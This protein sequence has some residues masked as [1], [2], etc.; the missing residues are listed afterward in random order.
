MPRRRRRFS[1]LGL[2]YF[3]VTLGLLL[4][5]SVWLDR[6]GETARAVVTRKYE[7]ISVHAVPLGGWDR[8][9][10]VGVQFPT[11]E[12]TLGMATLT[13]P[14]A[15]YDALRPGDS[16]AVHYPPFFPYLARAADRTTLQALGDAGRQ[17]A[18]DPILVPLILWLVAG[19]GSLWLASR[20][21]TPII[22]VVGAGWIVAAFLYLFPAA[23]P[24][25]GGPA[26]ATAR[27]QGVTLIAKA[28]ARRVARR[29]RFSEA[30]GDVRRLSVPYQVA[31]LSFAMPGGDSVLAVDAVDSGSVAGLAFGATVP[32]RYD[33]REPRAARIAG[34]T[35]T[36]LERNRYHF[37]VPVIG[38]AILGMLGAWGAR[39][40]RTRSWREPGAATPAVAPR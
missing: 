18:A 24:P 25:A 33:P 30:F 9:Y 19:I 36:F 28:P 26:A 12:G 34:G 29:R 40:R 22:A 35:R 14:R 17:M 23:H 32:V 38:L 3:V 16:V 10:R 39:S 7:E 20:I 2:F 15:R 4:G 31:Q 1:W 21:A 13:L 8:W 27:V 37:R 11:Q 6:R 5:G